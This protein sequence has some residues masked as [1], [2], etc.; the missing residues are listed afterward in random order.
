MRTI[1]F[2]EARGN[3]K[4]V[5][6]TV[7]A[8]HVITIVTR[9]D[10]EDAV[11]MSMSDYNSLQETLYLFATRTNSQ[12]LHAAMSEADDA[13]PEGALILEP[14]QHNRAGIAASD[15]IRRAATR[16]RL[17]KRKALKARLAAKATK[18]PVISPAA[19]RVKRKA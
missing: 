2:S 4:E 9:R 11:I 16:A 15:A 10:S 3:L 17:L 12:R 8:D 5:L 19:S 6:D 1:N 13:L 14:Q 18:E 7:A